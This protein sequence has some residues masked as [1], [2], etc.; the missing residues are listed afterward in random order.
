MHLCKHQCLHPCRHQALAGP[1]APGG[2]PRRLTN[3]LDFVEEL[4]ARLPTRRDQAFDPCDLGLQWEQRLARI[5]RL[6]LL[7]LLVGLG[8]QDVGAINDLVRHRPPA[9]A[10][11]GADWNAR[12]PD[13]RGSMAQV[14]AADDFQTVRGRME[15]LRQERERVDDA[16]SGAIRE[17]FGKP[18]GKAAWRLLT[19]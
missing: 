16:E 3:E 7:R 6:R 5:L 8:D 10:R 2:L 9:V 12:R 18:P 1:P 13:G 11:A 17:D 4:I 14:Q 15:E 19:G